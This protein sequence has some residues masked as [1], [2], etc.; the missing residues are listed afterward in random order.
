M[1]GESLVFAVLLVAFIALLLIITVAQRTSDARGCRAA[2]G[3]WKT[4][5]ASCDYQGSR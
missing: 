2:G 4:F 1:K 3:H 5:A